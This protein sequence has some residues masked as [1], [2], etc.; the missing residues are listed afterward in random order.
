M[1]GIPFSGRAGKEL[2]RFFELLEVDRTE[3]YITSAFRSRP[4]R[5][6]EKMDRKTQQLI[7]R[8][9]NRPPT[10]QELIAHAPL[11]DYEVEK[12]QTPYILTMG[13]IGLQRLLG[14]KMKV[15]EQHGKLY[16]G[17]VMCLVS[18]ENNAY[19]WTEK[20]YAVFPTFHPASIF[21]NRE[22]VETIHGDLAQ[23]KK[24]INKT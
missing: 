5:Y 4:Y 17:P 8:K 3:V 2:M 7:Y 19:T 18:P 1:N 12:I 14:P 20:R 15:S 9:Y 24:L 11:L 23:F 16:H 10:K 6:K 21:Y 13:N 22:L